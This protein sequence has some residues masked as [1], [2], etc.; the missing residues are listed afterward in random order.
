VCQGRLLFLIMYSKKIKIF[1]I[2]GRGVGK[3]H[4]MVVEDMCEVL[5]IRQIF[6][7]YD[8]AAGVLA[9]APDA[10]EEAYYIGL[11]EDKYPALAYKLKEFMA[12][13]EH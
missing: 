12:T 9:V 13:K 7:R 4:A 6:D 2:G 10:E 8:F 1:I 3:T 11:F 5:A